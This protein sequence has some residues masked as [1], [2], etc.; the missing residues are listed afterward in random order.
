MSLG[1]SL[2]D[3]LH[4]SSLPVTKLRA[5]RLESDRWEIKYA[6]GKAMGESMGEFGEAPGESLGESLLGKLLGERAARQCTG[7]VEGRC[8]YYVKPPS[9]KLLRP[10]QM[11]IER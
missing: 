2:E 10:R 3:L 8:L 1:E 9:D 6:S 7:L 11:P 4:I 5:S